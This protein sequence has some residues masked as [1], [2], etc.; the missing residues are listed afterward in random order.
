MKPMKQGDRRAWV[1]NQY[2]KLKFNLTC[3][4]GEITCDRL[5]HELATYIMKKRR[6]A[7]AKAKK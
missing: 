1:E 3:T 6:V 4:T 2:E 5:L 7:K